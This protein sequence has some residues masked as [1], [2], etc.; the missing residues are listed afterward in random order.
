[1]LEVAQGGTEIKLKIVDSERFL[2]P[3][4]N[5]WKYSIFCGSLIVS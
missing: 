1:M 2:C 3:N 5:T 4:F